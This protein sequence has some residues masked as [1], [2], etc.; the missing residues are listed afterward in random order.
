MPCKFILYI[1]FIYTLADIIVEEKQILRRCKLVNGHFCLPRICPGCLQ[2]Y[3]SSCHQIGAYL[4][5]PRSL[6]QVL[7]SSF[8]PFSES[9]RGFLCW[10][11][12]WLP[13]KLLTLLHLPLHVVPIPCATCSVLFCQAQSMFCCVEAGASL[14]QETDSL[15]TSY[16]K[17]GCHPH[18]TEIGGIS[19]VK[20]SAGCLGTSLTVQCRSPILQ[21]SLQNMQSPK[22]L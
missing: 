19:I 1:R 14:C 9:R 11:E 8:K 2:S 6:C 5:L 3:C 4:H 20:G 7:G 21:V 22:I 12:R 10:P 13:L 15:A 17:A 16:S 18:K